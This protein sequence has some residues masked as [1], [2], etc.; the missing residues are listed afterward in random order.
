M[1]VYFKNPI[2]SITVMNAPI[3]YQVNGFDHDIS[4]EKSILESNK[5]MK[6]QKSI[7]SLQQT[8]SVAVEQF[9]NLNLQSIDTTAEL[10]TIFEKSKP[11]F[12][13]Q[14]VQQQAIQPQ[15]TAQPQQP[16]QHPVQTQLPQKQY[17]ETMAAMIAYKISSIKNEPHSTYLAIAQ[18]LIDM[19]FTENAIVEALKTVNSLDDAVNLL[20]K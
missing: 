11:I 10:K 12:A 1:K 14:L 8:S 19:G 4:L 16:V 18:S 7:H 6:S 9:E 2:P 13:P 15:Y 5:Q 17:N 3:L 20:L